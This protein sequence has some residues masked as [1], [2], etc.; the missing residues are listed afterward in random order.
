MKFSPYKKIT[1]CDT[2]E[3]YF[4]IGTI[5]NKLFKFEILK[6]NGFLNKK[7]VFRMSDIKQKIKTVFH[8]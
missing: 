4:Y 6:N 1:S 8:R 3:Y 5:Q 2:V 7:N